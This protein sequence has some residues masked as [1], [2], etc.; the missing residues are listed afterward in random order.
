MTRPDGG[1]QAVKGLLQVSFPV[2]QRT[3][4][5]LRGEGA[6]PEEEQGG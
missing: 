3:S 2:A 1:L 5:H 4:E 6:V